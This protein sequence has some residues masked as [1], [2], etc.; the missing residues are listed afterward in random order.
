MADTDLKKINQEDREKR[1]EPEEDINI[2]IMEFI[3]QLKHFFCNMFNILCDYIESPLVLKESKT[4]S[5][6]A[7]KK[8]Y[9]PTYFPL[10]GGSRKSRKSRRS[11]RSIRSIKSIKNIN[12]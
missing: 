9:K 5:E 3:K 11:R 10:I 6:F 12:I 7:V 1:E 2:Y 4:P 8:E